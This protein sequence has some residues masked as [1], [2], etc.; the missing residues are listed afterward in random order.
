MH[1]AVKTS[2]SISSAKATFKS[3]KSELEKG[4]FPVKKRLAPAHIDKIAKEPHPTQ[5]ARTEILFPTLSGSLLNL[6]LI[7][8]PPATVMTEDSIIKVI[9]S[10]LG[11]VTP[12]LVFPFH[13]FAVVDSLPPPLEEISSND[14]VPLKWM[15]S[16]DLSVNC[17]INRTVTRTR[18]IAVKTENPA[19]GR[20][21][22]S[23]LTR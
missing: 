18:Q 6:S 14:V 9:H 10:M 12:T 19:T 20:A 23:V 5:I 22:A 1:E 11:D 21:P 2:G 3:P 4:L 8:Y 13:T 17:P 15:K 16:R 7:P